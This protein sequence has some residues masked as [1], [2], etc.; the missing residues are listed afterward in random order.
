[1]TSETAFALAT[2]A[3]IAGSTLH[4]ALGIGLNEYRAYLRPSFEAMVEEDL[5]VAAFEDEGCKMVGCLILTDFHQ[6]L[7]RKASATGKFAPLAALTQALCAEYNKQRSMTVG[8]VVLADMGAV[9]DRA[10]GT[11]TYQKMRAEAQRL[12]RKKGFTRIVGELSSRA[13]QHVVLDKL[14]HEKI[15]EVTFA[16]FEYAGQFPF[17][18]ITEPESIVLAEGLI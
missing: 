7:E 6:P 16:G 9:S 14:G 10:T 1:M 2:E 15:C 11:G 8:E 12:A 18:S 4:R 13:T 5:S 17:R 3:F